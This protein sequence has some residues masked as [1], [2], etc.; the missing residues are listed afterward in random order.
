MYKCVNEFS[1]VITVCN[2]KGIITY[3]NDRAKALFS[4]DKGE[5]MLGSNLYDCHPEPSKSKL[6]HLIENE[7]ENLYTV[8]KN[9]QKK[10][11]HQ[12]P[13]YEDG[14]YVAYLEMS[15]ILPMNMPHYKRDTK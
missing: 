15:T 3:M 12:T 2:T 13:L 8:E 14:K 9:G 4:N 10:L 1:S 6:R 11:I 5:Q 7:L